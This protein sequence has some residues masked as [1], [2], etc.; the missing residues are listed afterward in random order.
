MLEWSTEACL[1]PLVLTHRAPT[2][3]PVYPTLPY[4][5]DGCAVPTPLFATLAL[6]TY[7]I[8]NRQEI[9]Q[10]GGLVHVGEDGVMQNNQHFL[11]QAARELGKGRQK[12]ATDAK[13]VFFSQQGQIQR[14]ASPN[15]L[16]SLRSGQPQFVA[17]PVLC[18]GQYKG[19]LAGSGSEFQS[20][21][22][23]G[24]QAGNKSEL[25]GSKVGLL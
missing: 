22:A 23:S 15:I 18:L 9:D 11:V 8:G 5:A 7:V 14:V 1:G 13:R 20:L 2:G 17:P 3:C 16:Q 6:P 12:G 19:L 4:P 24:G 25:V 21:A 10:E